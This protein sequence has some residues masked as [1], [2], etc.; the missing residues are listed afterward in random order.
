[1]YC[2][3]QVLMF[4]AL[5]S[6][7]PVSVRLRFYVTRTGR[8]LTGREA[9]RAEQ[10]DRQAAKKGPVVMSRSTI[11]RWEQ[12][13]RETGLDKVLEQRIYTTIVLQTRRGKVLLCRTSLPF[14]RIENPSFSGM[15]GCN[16]LVGLSSSRYRPPG[17]HTTIMPLPLIL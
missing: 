3:I 8:R 9:H 14:L 5:T 6:L 12:P 17:H 2:C 4:S 1:M 11:M 13:R 15:P 10:E 7:P 16:V